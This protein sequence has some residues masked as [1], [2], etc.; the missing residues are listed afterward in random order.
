MDE[1]IFFKKCYLEREDGYVYLK[2]ISEKWTNKKRSP[3]D[4]I[5]KIV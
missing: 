4:L 5:A 1:C 2:A 3:K